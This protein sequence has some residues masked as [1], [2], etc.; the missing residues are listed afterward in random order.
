MMVTDKNFYMERELVK[1][2][3]IMVDRCNSE[4][5]QDNLILLDGDEGSGKSNLSV[6]IAYYMAWKS[7]RKFDVDDVYFDVEKIIH[8][9]IAED[10]YARIFVWDEAALKGLASDWQNQWQKTLIK[11][12][13]IA[14]KRRHI[15]IFNIPKFFRLN[16][17]IVVDRSLA[18][19]H[20]YLQKEVK[21]GFFVYY[22]KK[23]KAK[24]YFDYRKTRRRSY[25]NHF[26]FR[27][28]CNWLL[29]KLIN[30]VEYERKK[31]EA[32]MSLD[33]GK[34]KTDTRKVYLIGMLDK[35]YKDDKKNNIERTQK[36]YADLMKLSQD[37]IRRYLIELGHK[38]EP[39]RY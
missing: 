21:P 30:E 1:K 19:I 10:S 31:D 32:I 17:Y 16:E 27:G 13:M 20:T 18:L 28:R 26:T 29:P 24:L 25:R 14:R 11:L 7:G 12:L 34:D 9:A 8:E 15:Y 35:L 5:K 2:L 4:N 33:K 3:D 22:N 36:Y 6:Q 37:T 39:V 38:K 23:S